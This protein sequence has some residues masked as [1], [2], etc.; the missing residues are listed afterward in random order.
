[1]KLEGERLESL[2]T[3]M[4]EIRRF[5]EKTA[6]LLCM[7]WSRHRAFLRRGEAVRRRRAPI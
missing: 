1:M 4:V 6:E 7:V 2:Y 3:T 5:D